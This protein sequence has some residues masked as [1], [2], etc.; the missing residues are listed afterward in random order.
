[1]DAFVFSDK[2]K[3]SQSF[4]TH[5]LGT[6]GAVMRRKFSYEFSGKAGFTLVELLVVIT[7]IG[8]LITLL[9]PAVNGAR[10][11]ARQMVCKNHLK[12]MTT[13]MMSHNAAHS[14]RFP[15]GGDSYP[16]IGDSD[17]GTAG[18][19]GG[20]TSNAQRGGWPFS[21]SEFI[22]IGNV[23]NAGLQERCITP[24]PM[25]YCPSRRKPA[26][27][28]SKQR[29]IWDGTKKEQNPYL[30][31]KTDY[32]A[33]S[34]D[35]SGPEVGH[36]NG[37]NAGGVIFTYSTIFDKDITDGLSKTALLGEKHLD[38]RVYKNN[39]DDPGD[40]DCFLAGRNYDSIR[41]SGGSGGKIYRDRNGWVGN[42]VFGSA[43]PSGLHMTFC[44]GHLAT[45]SYAV[46]SQTLCRLINRKDG[47]AVS[48]KDL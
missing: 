25:M 27:Y 18:Q 14:G 43:H 22:G 13:G 5:K 19:I 7:I 3:R 47:Y 38:Q 9:V 35:M 17:R 6:G 12:Q 42:T 45:I 37:F 20:N 15:T 11:V 34:G 46:S 2:E 8:I 24:L 4:L 31:S 16:Y 23:K 29:D 21:I 48:D 36:D 30:T 32:A 44:D 40:D 39:G 26:L 28:R 10:E 41:V 1:M 33:N